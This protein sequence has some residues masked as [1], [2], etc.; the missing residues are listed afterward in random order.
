[1]ARRPQLR[2]DAFSR[3]KGQ[4]PFVDNGR[5]GVSVSVDEA[6][7]REVFEG[8]ISAFGRAAAAA[9][10]Q[11]REAAIERG[12]AHIRSKG[13]PSTWSD[14]LQSRQYPKRGKGSLD[15]KAFVNYRFGGVGTVFEF[16]TEISPKNGKY[17]W[18]PADGAKKTV[19]SPSA[20]KSLR[21]TPARLWGS[22]KG[23][24]FAFVGGR[25]AL[26]QRNSKAKVPKVMFWGVGRDRAGNVKPVK[27]PKK[28]NVLPII[29]AEAAK[30]PQLIETNLAQILGKRGGR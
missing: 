14:A 6:A 16:G 25:P 3:V 9:V 24:K 4:G 15:V 22:A 1:M 8:P 19:W 27:I 21:A 29:E 30:L 18:I 12:R 7:I 20:R 11:A 5:V 10:R 17:L 2:S 26:V 23:L 28:W 13:F